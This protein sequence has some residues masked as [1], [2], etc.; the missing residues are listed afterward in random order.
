[1]EEEIPLIEIQE[2]LC[3]FVENNALAWAPIISTWSLEL[4][5]T[6]PL[7]VTSTLNNIRL[8]TCDHFS[9][10]ISSR[11]GSHK[12]VGST[13]NER[14]Q[15]WTVCGATRTLLDIN[16]Q[17][18]SRLM[19]SNTESCINALLD[20]SVTHSPHFDWVIVHVGSSFPETVITK[21][22]TCGL[23]DF[24]NNETASQVRIFLYFCN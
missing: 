21:V 12:H 3:T 23:K 18:M 6:Y 16:T 14:L 19:Y 8:F 4:L 11:Y 20:M 13:L 7:I 10:D 22:L 24:Y 15:L 17:C 2:V 5:G 1:M 9:G